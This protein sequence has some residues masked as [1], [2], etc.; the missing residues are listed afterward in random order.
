MQYRHVGTAP[1][2]VV[3]IDVSYPRLGEFRFV[4]ALFVETDDQSD[5][6]F[7]TGEMGEVIGRGEHAES[8]GGD[9]FSGVRTGEGD[10]FVLEYPVEVSVFDLFEVF[11]LL[12]V[13]GGWG[14]GMCMG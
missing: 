7:G 1:I 4:V 2:Q 10:D 6:E 9:E 13:E 14:W 11:V 12:D 5:V 8:L 3:M